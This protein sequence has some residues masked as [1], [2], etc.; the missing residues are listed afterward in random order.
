MKSI[1]SSN[2]KRIL[3]KGKLKYKAIGF[4]MKKYTEDSKQIIRKASANNKLVVFVGSGVSANSGIPMWNG[5][6]NEIKERIDFDS[7]NEQD[8]L[9]IA[10]YFYNSRGEKEYY[11]LLKDKL[12][13]DVEP[14]ELDDK[15]LELNP[16]HIIT[17]NYDNLIESQA[18]KKG[19]FY[20]V[21]SKDSDLPYTPNGRMII[22]M[23]GD[24]T[25][26]N[27]VFKEDDYLS[28]SNNFKLIETFIKS[29]FAT[30]TVLFVGYSL[31]D[32]DIKYIF[33][34]VKD[35]LKKDLPRPYFL[36][37]DDSKGFNMAE[38]QYYQNMGINLLYYS[39]IENR[40]RKKLENKNE[41][42]EDVIGRKTLSFLEYL[43]YDYNK[44]YKEEE[45]HKYIQNFKYLNYI[46]KKYFIKYLQNVVGLRQGDD[47]LFEGENKLVFLVNNNSKTKKTIEFISALKSIKLEFE[48]KDFFKKLNVNT[49]EVE[50]R[51][52]DKETNNY[53]R[54]RKIILENTESFS[55]T[56]IDEDI[57]LHRFSKLE[58]LIN[59]YNSNMDLKKALQNAYA[60]YFTGKYLEAYKEYKKI[61]NMALDKMDYFIHDISE[62]NRFYCGH[63]VANSL[64]YD[65]DISNEI[66]KEVKS[67][68]LEEL[69]LKWPLNF[70]QNYIIKDIINWNFVDKKT[71]KIAELKPE[72]DK[73]ES[74]VY[75][76]ISEKSIA[77]NQL[78]A[79][80]R[81]LWNY[82]NYNF[83]TIDNFREITNVCYNY[84]DI[85]VRNYMTPKKISND[86]FLGKAENVKIEEFE[87]FDIMCMMKYINEK[88]LEKIFMRYKVNSLEIKKD[89]IDKVLEMFL[90]VLDFRRNNPKINRYNI[91]SILLLLSKIKLSQQQFDRINEKLIDYFSSKELETDEVNYLNKY[92]YYQF[93][94]FDNYCF[95]FYNRILRQ[96]LNKAEKFE[97]RDGEIAIV[98]NITAYIKE[99]EPK[100]VLKEFD[101]FL[102]GF[103]VGN[104]SGKNKLLIYF[105]RVC[106]T[107][108]RAKISNKT[109]NYLSRIVSFSASDCELYFE[110]VMEKIIEKN[111]LFEEKFLNEIDA[112]KKSKEEEEKKGI[113][114]FPDWVEVL[115][116]EVGILKLNS[117]IVDMNRFK[118]F[119]GIYDYFDF[120]Y[121][122][123]N[124]N[125]SKFNVEW[126]KLFGTKFL[127]E[128]SANAKLKKEIT[129]QIREKLEKY[130]DVDND[131]MKKYMKYFM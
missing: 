55:Y 84:I 114:S 13:L 91:K 102:D 39:Q 47:Y 61:S 48:I 57:L 118:K 121:D 113:K 60:L 89:D 97:I 120:M 4:N 63:I 126:I 7:E 6:I 127:E 35:I 32:P 49:V 5:I 131:L 107:D 92:T 109:N 44:E 51:E 41:K 79:E 17:T 110:S 14:N 104:N 111:D 119:L 52:V 27:I 82:I 12:D 66:R 128:L 106:S 10:Q 71:S 81:D 22:K 74:T 130:E 67:I 33:K 64:Y 54:D 62:F 45:F 24:F 88:E 100:K 40:I 43:L 87:L 26:R 129:K 98:N 15:I 117:S 72:I 101:E 50:Y 18:T 1:E 103:E 99:K 25:N 68:I 77:I 42:V 56:D 36:K 125:Y 83:F 95:T 29:I 19:M 38:Y 76:W 21:V 11:D 8:N 37:I 108:Y 80:I 20:D 30:H 65:L 115:L 116:E 53:V 96:I 23:H 2:E 93:E 112:S 28:Y 90:N 122:I 16:Y 70:T 3:K 86:V 123:E 85:L 31:K 94:K 9:V 46:D 69:Q 34:W 78:K 105:Y 59:K 58:N 73:N 124:F 75:S